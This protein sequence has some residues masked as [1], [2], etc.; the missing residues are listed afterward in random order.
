M[1]RVRG[2]SIARVLFVASFASA[3]ALVLAGP[4]VAQ[5]STSDLGEDDQIVLNGRLVVPDGES[6]D[7]GVIFNGPATVGGTVRGSLVVFNGRTEI[8]GTV[9]K[10]VVV[11]NGD[12]VL[13]S[14]A[15]VRGDVVTQSDPQIEEGATIEGDRQNIATRFD[16]ENIGF[17]SR[18]AWW[19]AYSVSTLILGLLLLLLL[20]GLD[21]GAI[22]AWRNRTG[23][24]IGWGVGAF[25]LVPIAAVIFLLT[26]VAI[27][28]GLFLL[29]G[30]ALLYTIGYVVGAHVVGR[31][32]LKEP[33][34]RFLAFLLGWVIL[35]G[36]ALIPFVGGFVW[37]IASILGLGV[38]TVAARR[39][40]HP[41]VVAPAVPSPPPLPT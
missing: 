33:R 12:V 16:F 27:P 26:V 7:T 40:T 6:I 13:R 11:F 5:E 29:L 35:R 30:I 37:L 4:A 8:S 10:D 21:A 24:S 17:A 31:L 38:L 15:E 2:S 34:S 1:A 39:T 28:L 20:P 19:V 9:E 3:A 22:D 25:F 23:E 14:G 18:F 41:G 36:L 32:L